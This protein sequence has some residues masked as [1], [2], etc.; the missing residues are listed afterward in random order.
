MTRLSLL[1]I[2]FATAAAAETPRDFAFGIPLVTE[3]DAAFYRV[4]LP[5]AVYEGAT[6]ADRSDLRVFNTD[7]AMVP[8][9]YLPAADPVW[10]KDAPVAVPI[11]PLRVEQSEPDLN[12]LALSVNRTAAGATLNLTTRDGRPVA[13]ERLVGYVVDA[14]AF[15]EPIEALILAWQ[16]PAPGVSTRVHVEAGDDLA[17]WRSLADAPLIDLEY[18]GRRLTRD[19]IEFP[20]TKA[21]YLRLSWAAGQPS[22]E[23]TGARVGARQR[24]I[25][26]PRRWTEAGGAPVPEHAGDYEF[27]L[28]G[29]F[30]VDRV[31]IDL[32]EINSVVP[33]Q[34]LARASAQDPWQPVASLVVYR[35]R[36][37]NAEV[38]SPAATVNARSLRY[39]MLRVDP[40][41]GGLG[42]GRPRLRA[43]WLA[44]ELV[45]AARGGAP[46]TI[47]YGSATAVRTALPIAT[48]VPGYGT[49]SAPPIERAAAQPGAAIALG[50]PDRLRKGIDGKRLLLWG[51]LALGVALLGWMAW[52]L[53]RQLAAPAGGAETTQRQDAR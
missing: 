27:D 22:V 44:R 6:G 37:A 49:A 21:K 15:E 8:F 1:A 41:S 35:L 17:S 25:E 13:G 29:A 20:A 7:D 18:S 36:L 23:L 31:V 39:W 33:A 34:L 45:F 16:T 48:L 14:S 40:N 50:G 24:V 3:G 5:A 11:F 30:P 10:R 4:E 42:T 2:L 47:A 43:G 26:P 9:A 28:G 12:G 38:A 52:R 32:P 53:S 46:F 51:T 19:R